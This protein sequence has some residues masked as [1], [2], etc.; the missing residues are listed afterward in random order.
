MGRCAMRQ[1]SAIRGAGP[2]AGGAEEDAGGE[3]EN[4]MADRQRGAEAEPEPRAPASGAGAVGPILSGY[5]YLCGYNGHVWN[6]Q[7]NI[8]FWDDAN[9]G[10]LGPGAFALDPQILLMILIREI[11]GISEHFLVIVVSSPSICLMLWTNAF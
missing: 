10:L 11:L 1:P 3:A 7:K 4:E 9:T 2:R 8:F 5:R 6:R